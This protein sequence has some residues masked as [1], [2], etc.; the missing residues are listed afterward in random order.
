MS[1]GFSISFT[2]RCHCD[3]GRIG[4]DREGFST[5]ATTACGRCNGVGE[6]TSTFAD[7]LI[8]V[9][10]E[11]PHLFRM[12]L[13]LG[14]P[15]DKAIEQAE[16]HFRGLKE[17]WDD[18]DALPIKWGTLGKATAFLR[19]AEYHDHVIPVPDIVPVRDG[20]VDLEW[21][22]EAYYILLNFP[23]DDGKGPT[24]S[25]RMGEECG[26]GHIGFDVKYALRPLMPKE[27]A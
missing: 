22:T 27:K 9:M 2:A 13:G 1:P 26:N 21:H 16:T 6:Q 3:G 11:H 24:Y 17:G 15:M 5:D 19:F 18:E 10:T 23:E 14:T 4:L 8:T 7:E 25:W 12:A 20:S